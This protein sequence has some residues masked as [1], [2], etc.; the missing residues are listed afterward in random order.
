MEFVLDIVHRSMR[1]LT[2]LNL[3]SDLHERPTFPGVFPP[4][5]RKLR[6]RLERIQEAGVLFIHIPRNAGMSIS[7]SLYG[8]QVFHPTIRYYARVA[9]GLVEQLPSF[10][11]GRDPVERFV[12]AYQF[13]LA[14]GGPDT[15]VSRA[16]RQ[17]YR[18]FANIDEAI[19]HVAT[20]RSLYQLDHIF[21]PQFWYI[22]DAAGRIA[23]DQVCQLDDL[24]MA[25]ENSL[26]PG[27]RGIDWINR[28]APADVTLDE[29]QI[30]RLQ[31]IYPIDFAIQEALSR[32][33]LANK[34][35]SVCTAGR[36]GEARHQ[37]A[38]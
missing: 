20:A 17:R 2:G 26:L 16:F 33:S 9:P 5:D 28:S 29:S 37:I 8:E 32:Q 23:V 30:R 21:R 12:S 31:A 35:L 15:P 6:H 34:A 18:S 1:R 14:G 22:T 10:A 25:V 24:E 11:V 7:A 36:A 27:L 38:A 4:L 13:G 19:E 3:V